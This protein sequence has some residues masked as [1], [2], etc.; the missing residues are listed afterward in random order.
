MH[1]TWELVSEVVG[2]WGDLVVCGSAYVIDSPKLMEAHE[3]TWKLNL[4]GLLQCHVDR[5]KLF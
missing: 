2:M 3:G 1:V 4:G 5:P